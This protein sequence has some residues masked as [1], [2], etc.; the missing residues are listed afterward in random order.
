MLRIVYAGSPDISAR[1][2]TELVNSGV[3]QVVAV[4]TNPPS[5]QGR[6]KQLVPTPVALAAEAANKMVNSTTS[7]DSNTTTI[8]INATIP[9]NKTT[10][11]IVILTPEKLDGTLREQ[12]AV[13]KP[14][15][16]V[17]FA[18]G[19]LFGPKFMA[20]FPLGGINLHPSLLPKYRG[21]APVPV[22]ILNRENETGVTIQRLAHEMDSGDILLQ[23][24]IPLTGRETSGSLLDDVS[25][26]G[27]SLLIEVLQKID[28]CQ[29]SGLPLDCRKQDGSQATFCQM[30]QKADGC[31][32]WK[33]SAA[34]IDAQ[35]RAFSP[36]PGAF[37]SLDGTVL[38]IHEA[39]IA[40]AKT[41]TVESQTSVDS[42]IVPGTVIGSNKKDGIL[43]QTGNG[44]LAVTNLQWQAKK[45]MNWKDFLNGSRSFIGSILGIN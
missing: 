21:C 33:K 36:W 19:K 1:P 8:V 23:K 37:T 18:Y 42:N 14:D 20:L 35:I 40:E 25:T 17:C 34:E 43:I 6:S 15:L 13:L 24:V 44:V 30:L 27:G 9:A 28:Q 11:P 38:R 39:T 16:L 4:L 41:A 5:P 22:A 12:I 31:I 2:L 45:A 3:C 7:P 29:K 32:D 26:Q 10:A